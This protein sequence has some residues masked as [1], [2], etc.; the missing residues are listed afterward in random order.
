MLTLPKNGAFETMFDLN[1]RTNVKLLSKMNAYIP[2]ER[3][4]TDTSNSIHEKR[5]S[6]IQSVH[7][8]NEET[9]RASPLTKANNLTLV[10]PDVAFSYFSSYVVVTRSWERRPSVLLVD[11]VIGIVRLPSMLL[12]LLLVSD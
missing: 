7:I 6:T 10:S 1:S 4:T 2:V 3:P 11:D 12:P 8:K 9:T 5:W